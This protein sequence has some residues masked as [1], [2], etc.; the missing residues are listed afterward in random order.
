MWEVRGKKKKEKI[1]NRMAKT[2]TTP[3]QL[4]INSFITHSSLHHSFVGVN[5]VHPS[6]PSIPLFFYPLSL[7]L[8]LSQ[9]NVNDVPSIAPDSARTLTSSPPPFLHRPV[10]SLFSHTHMHSLSFSHPSL[11]FSPLLFPPPYISHPSLSLTKSL[12]FGLARPQPPTS[13]ITL[14]SFTSFYAFTH[15]YPSL[16]SSIVLSENLPSLHLFRIQSFMFTHL[17]FFII[18]VPLAPLS[19]I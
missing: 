3:N 6:P 1:N 16:W 15:R 8:Q 2:Q 17:H 19:L 5:F 14:L 12:H 13:V 11:S 10:I 7:S 9:C 18:W 4:R